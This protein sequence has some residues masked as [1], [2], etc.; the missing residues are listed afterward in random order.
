MA[1]TE[2]LLL[3]RLS[4]YTGVSTTDIKALEEDA[5]FAFVDSLRLNELKDIARYFKV[6]NILFVSMRD[7]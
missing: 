6:F 4:N 5:K 3:K 2:S 7:V 1:N